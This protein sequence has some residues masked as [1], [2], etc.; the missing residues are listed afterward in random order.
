MA[1]CR[2]CNESSRSGA[3]QATWLSQTVSILFPEGYQVSNLSTGG[4]RLRLS[5]KGDDAPLCSAGAGVVYAVGIS[6]T[7]SFPGRIVVVTNGACICKP[8]NPVFGFL[9]LRII[10][11]WD[12]YFPMLAFR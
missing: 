7:G 9:L 11:K 1:A 8:T 3:W 12:Q 6:F 5:A 4:P 10:S 2:L